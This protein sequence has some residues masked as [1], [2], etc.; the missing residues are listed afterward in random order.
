MTEDTSPENL[1]KFLKSDDPA[2]VRMGLSM[3]KGSGVSE[4][5][6]GDILWIC[7]VHE[8]QTIHATAKSTFMKLAPEDTKQFMKK[9]KWKEREPI[10]M[11]LRT[12][13]NHCSYKLFGKDGNN[14]CT[15]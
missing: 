4:E 2:M 7:M 3:A 12:D 11:K 1:R 15:D 6:L 5:L 14:Y 8:D 13:F 10:L 9:W